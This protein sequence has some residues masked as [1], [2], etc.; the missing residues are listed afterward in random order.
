[1]LQLHIND[2]ISIKWRWDLL[3]LKLKYW[4]LACSLQSFISQKFWVYFSRCWWLLCCVLEWYKLQYRHLCPEFGKVSTESVASNAD[5]AEQEPNPNG[6]YDL[7][8]RNKQRLPLWET[9]SDQNQYNTF[10]K[11]WLLKSLSQTQL[12]FHWRLN[13]PLHPQSSELPLHLTQISKIYLKSHLALIHPAKFSNALTITCR[14]CL[15]LLL[16]PCTATS[17]S[18]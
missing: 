15:K 18:I 13:L 4:Q 10:E 6:I 5:T 12:R 3:S 17:S 8:L 16:Y 2:H 14:A 9:A 1:M 11:T 7:R